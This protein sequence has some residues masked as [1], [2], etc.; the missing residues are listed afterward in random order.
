MP[1]P[2][3]EKFDAKI[4]GKSVKVIVKLKKGYKKQV[5]AKPKKSDVDTPHFVKTHN[6]WEVHQDS[7]NGEYYRVMQPQ[8]IASGAFHTME[9]YVRNSGLDLVVL[10]TQE[11]ANGVLINTDSSGVWVTMPFWVGNQTY[12]WA[13]GKWDEWKRKCP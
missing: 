3:P 5:F 11:T 8:V 1:M 12:F 13:L 7:A 4:D 9:N 10:P 6:I 2:K